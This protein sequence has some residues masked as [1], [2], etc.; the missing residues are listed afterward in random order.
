MISG[1]PPN[2]TSAQ[3][4]PGNFSTGSGAWATIYLRRGDDALNLP[5][6]TIRPEWLAEADLDAEA[7][8][9]YRDAEDDF[10]A[11]LIEQAE[12]RGVDLSDPKART[13]FC[14]RILSAEVLTRLNL[15]RQLAGH[16]KTNA[17]TAAVTPDSTTAGTP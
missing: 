7:M 17:V 10:L 12:K 9:A 4:Q 5:A 15:L 3:L 16:V 1:Q 8:A 13:E 6:L 14:R 11:T 2:T